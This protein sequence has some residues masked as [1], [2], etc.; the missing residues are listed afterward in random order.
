MNSYLKEDM[1]ISTETFATLANF[2]QL[3][4]LKNMGVD[5]TREDIS[6]YFELEKLQH[7]MLFCL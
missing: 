5:D 2:L 6:E 7:S 1:Q 3:V 4:G